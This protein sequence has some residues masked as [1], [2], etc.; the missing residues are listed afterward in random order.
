MTP[1]EA[2]IK[3]YVDATLSQTEKENWRTVKS[4]CEVAERVYDT[5]CKWDMKL[6]ATN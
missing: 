2:Y 5:E 3:A 4:Q 1:R 6:N